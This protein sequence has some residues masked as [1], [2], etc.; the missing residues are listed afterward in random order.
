M[1]VT[2]GSSSLVVPMIMWGRHPPVHCISSIY[3]LRDQKTLVSGSSDGQVFLWEVN[4]QSDKWEMTPRH[5]LVGHT[6][7]IKCIAKASGGTDGHHIVTSSE[8]GEMFCWDTED[9]RCIESKKLSGLI[10]THIQAYRSPDA[11][12]GSTGSEHSGRQSGVKL[13]CCGFYEEITVMDPFSLTVIFQLSS[14]INPDWVASFHVLR[15]RNRHDDV[16]LALTTTG[17]VK[18]WT[19][20][21]DEHLTTDPILENESKQIRCINAVSMTCCVYNMRTVLVVCATYWSIYDAGDFTC[22][23]T[24]DCARGE[25]WI[26]GEFISAERVAVWSDDGRAYLYRM[27]TNC[28][29]ESKD[30]HNKSKM[31]S[32]VSSNSLLF[33]QLV[34][35]QPDGKRGRPPLDCPPAFRY[36]IFSKDS[37]WV[38]YL[39]RGDANGRL[40]V[41]KIPDTPQCASMQLKRQQT[42]VHEQDIGCA[43]VTEQKPIISINIEEI[44]AQMR[45]PPPGAL[46][47][48]DEPILE[49]V[50]KPGVKGS[51]LAANDTL[52]SSAIALTATIF[53]PM[54]CKLACGR[55]DGTIIMV[56]ATHTIMLQLLSGRHQK[57][58]NWPQHQVLL[59]HTGKVNCLLYPNNEHP[60]Y[61]VA[62]LISGSIDFSV[63]LWD[64]YT[65]TLLHRFCAHAGEIANLYIPPANCSPRIQQC[66]CSVAS[67]HSVTL[68]SLK[69]R[70]C[71]MLASR[72][73]FPIATIKWRPLDDFLMIGCVDGTT[74]IWQM[75]TGHL[76][77]VVHGNPGDEILAACDEHTATINVGDNVGAN[78]ALHFFRGLRHRNLAAI[79]LATMSQLQGKQG[80]LDQIQ[81]KSRAFPLNVSGFKMNPRDSEGHILFFDIEALVVQLLTE[82]YSAMSPGTMEAQGFTN[83]REYDRI[84]ALTKPASPDTVRKISGF[85]NKVK[86]RADEKITSLS[87]GA[88]PETQRRMTG[89]MAKVK[90]GAEKAKGELEHAKKEIEK[91]AGALDEEANKKDG[92]NTV[93]GRPSSLHLEINLTLEIGQLLLSLL[94]AWGLDKEL[95]RVAQTKLGLLRPKVPVSYGILSRGGVMSLMLPTW[96]PRNKPANESQP[97]GSELR[98][99][100][101]NNI[102]QGLSSRETDTTYFTALGHWELSHTITTNHL[103]SVIA[104]TNTLVSVSNASFIPEQERKRKLV[105]QATHGAMELSDANDSSAFSKQQETIKQGWS[106]LS[107]LHCLLLSGKLKRLGSLAFKK[108]QVELLAIR[109]QDRCLQ[110]RLAAQ[111]LLVAELK[112]LGLKGRRHLVELWGSYLP[113]Y[114]DPPFQQTGGMSSNSTVNTNNLQNGVAPVNGNANTS[115]SDQA[116]GDDDT[117]VDDDIDEDDENANQSAVESRR[118]QTTAVI[119][120]GV[121]GAL[122][123]LEAE[124]EGAGDGALALGM[125]MTRLTAKALM[126]LVL[127]SSPSSGFYNPGQQSNASQNTHANNNSGSTSSVTGTPKS[128][129]AHQNSVNQANNGSSSQASNAG[130]NSGSSGQYNKAMPLKQTGAKSGL[131]RAAIGNILTISSLL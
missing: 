28:I 68:L 110:I 116:E 94:H 9:G 8:N 34:M 122:F 67:D 1:T 95:D 84:W 91:R 97:I 86:D 25:R 81:E 90:E 88:S 19:L 115:S 71:V 15:P 35:D 70:R 130:G 89:I 6:A 3:L 107:T 131:R 106:L 42:S 23:L 118:N 75:E 93:N 32:T 120:L 48:L 124:I 77:R 63:C 129:N 7:P 109:W 128:S 54:Q 22:L 108:P 5:V 47:Q 14:R 100:Q 41:W 79:K 40:A 39:I 101:F 60:R 31:P 44:W 55:E 113:K 11:Q 125:H 96:Y 30:F 49:E 62:H 26:G 103:L 66:I 105:R 87:H 10:H 69:E 85:L 65:G 127:C 21:G 102:S 99:S 2:G 104:I 27:P 78:P 82:E 43:G 29:V 17:T 18:V 56:P 76:D 83:Q 111:E 59:G 61:D 72:H 12:A 37:K 13:F 112:N 121:I 64:I 117:D 98:T 80:P 38:K 74:Y 119:L 45:P 53:L 92:D 50:P 4:A 126:Y 73:M 52:P 33:C 20:N 36:L 123:D 58:Q 114:G 24:V 51:S 57:F 16:V 46:S